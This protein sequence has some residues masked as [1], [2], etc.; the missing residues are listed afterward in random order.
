MKYKICFAFVCF[1]ICLFAVAGACAGEANETGTQVGDSIGIDNQNS[2][3]GNFTQLSDSVKN[4]SESSV[5]SLDKDYKYDSGSADG[6]LIN[7]S[8]TIDGQNHV[9]DG[10]NGSRILLISDA[11]VTL[12]N[13]VFS[14]GFADEGGAVH[15]MNSTL[16]ISNCTFIHNRANADGGAIYAQLSNLSIEQSTFSYNCGEGIY[17]SGGA[18]HL[19]NSSARISHSTFLNNTADAGGAIF[20]LESSL[21]ITGS[22]F[23]YNM[24]SSYGGGVFCELYAKINS[25]VFNDNWAGI[26]G[27]AIHS[28]YLTGER[29]I[30]EVN[31]SRLFNNRA[32][33]GGAVSSSNCGY[34]LIQNSMLYSNEASYGAVLA[35]LSKSSAEILNCDCRDNVAINGTVVYAPTCGRLSLKR[36]NFTNNSGEYGVLVFSIQG[37]IQKYESDYNITVSGC[38]VTDNHVVDSVIYNFYAN[39][40][41]ENSS[42]VY[43]NGQY[44]VFVIKKF[45]NGNFRFE[46]NWWGVEN[47]DLSKLIYINGTVQSQ[48]F[49]LSSGNYDEDCSS[50]IIQIDENHT[51]SSFRR[52]SSVEVLVL[53]SGNGELRQEKLDSSYFFHMIVTREGWVMGN[54]GVD[55][56]YLNERIEA[57]ARKMIDRDEIS[58]IYLELIFST[59]SF[60]NWGHFI[61]KSPDGRYGIVN[62]FNNTKAIELDIL[63]SGEYILCPNNYELHKKG[64]VSD[65]PVSGY[66]EAS[67]YLAG[68]DLYGKYRTTV[69][70]YEYVREISG[71]R[72]T[73]HVDCYVSN[74]D[75]HLINLST[76]N[77]FNDIFFEG[78]Y[79]PGEEIPII[80]EGKYLGRMFLEEVQLPS[81][82]TKIT[83]GDLKIVYNKG[84]YLTVVLKDVNGNPVANA[85]LKINLNGNVYNRVTDSMGKAKL[86]VNPAPKTYKA[87]ISFAGKDRYAKSSGEVKITVKKATPKLTAKSKKFKKSKKVKRYTVIL[88]NNLGKAM[89]NAKLTLKIKGKKFKAKTNAKGKATFKIKKLS[90]KGTYQAKVTYKA[91]RYYTKATKKVKIKLR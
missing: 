80:M 89:K 42:F 73:A 66:V 78:R 81:I 24:A 25:S 29:G 9:L 82:E 22:E 39:L 90:K 4:A 1:L 40:I 50:N 84:K 48:G 11:K 91:N 70:T 10:A 18:V 60:N 15:L 8:L 19:F 51:V 53:I 63:H 52:D 72:M 32:P 43:K 85:D 35:R 27:G 54:G 67:R 5:L 23:S 55:A 65:L 7:K 64:N 88:K 26:K 79:I 14:N 69:Q 20:S 13:L 3:V 28:S 87:Y 34:T 75:G 61:I 83:A 58:L 44:Q 71:S 38:N 31:G 45:A 56:P 41:V 47:P 59:K 30:L 16:L 49:I 12:K 86:F 68:I 46:N 2:G 76:G 37:R 62:Y 74:D 21:N 17:V 33:F 36:S 6:I 57:I 77:Y